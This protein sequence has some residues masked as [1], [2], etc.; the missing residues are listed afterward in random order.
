M[1]VG[2]NCG[3]LNSI[4]VLRIQN[5]PCKLISSNS[6][7]ANAVARSEHGVPGFPGTPQHLCD[8]NR[9]DHGGHEN[10]G[11]F[12]L[13]LNPSQQSLEIQNDCRFSLEHNRAERQVMQAGRM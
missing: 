11:R 3:C 4:F 1:N 9:F 6:S 7:S 13:S 12:D 5:C 2:S 10:P 8:A